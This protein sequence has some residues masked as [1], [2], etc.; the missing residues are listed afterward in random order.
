MK[1][2]YLHKNFRNLSFEKKTIF[3]SHTVTLLFCFFPW[4]SA[5]PVYT[6]E[7]FYTAFGGPSFLMGIIIFFISFVVFLLFLDQLF[8]KQK[9]NLPVSE[10]LLYFTAGAQ[11]FLLLILVWSV[12]TMVGRDFEN[13]EIRFGLFLAIISQICGLVATFLNYQLDQQKK[14][15]E[16]FSHT[17]EQKK[18]SNK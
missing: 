17:T 6:E 9:I 1:Y 15:K 16:F 14:A 3:L 13:H 5:S 18:E 11:Q 7:F 8:E 10:N 4:F 12:L 2:A